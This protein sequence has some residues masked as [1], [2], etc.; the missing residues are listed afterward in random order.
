MQRELTRQMWAMKL[1]E[2]EIISLIFLSLFIQVWSGVEAS[3]WH[4]HV[5]KLDAAWF[6]RLTCVCWFSRTWLLPGG[7]QSSQLC[8]VL[9]QRL[10]ALFCIWTTRFLPVVYVPL[11]LFLVCVC[12]GG[13]GIACQL[14]RRTRDR[15][16]ASWNPGRSSRRI[17]F[18]RVK[19]VCWLLFGVRSTPVLPQWHV[20]DP[21]HSAKVQVAGYT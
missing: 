4:F 15:K 21:G 3:S 14:E 19:F 5:G 10:L 7:W 1:R 20:K 18:C 12:V 11:H 8:G 16:V 6:P 9:Q 13:A 2:K 17:F